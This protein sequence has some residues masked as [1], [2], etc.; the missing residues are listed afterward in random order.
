MPGGVCACAPTDVLG[1]AQDDECRDV[2]AAAVVLRGGFVRG[3]GG[4]TGGGGLPAGDECGGLTGLDLALRPGTV[5][6][7]R[8]LLREILRCFFVHGRCLNAG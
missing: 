7:D 6:A 2:A 5:E 1:G 3:G 8:G 4:G